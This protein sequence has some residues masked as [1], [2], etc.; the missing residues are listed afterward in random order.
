MNFKII[1]TSEDAI[2]E[3]FAL[4]DKVG[5]NVGSDV[6]LGRDEGWSDGGASGIPEGRLEGLSDKNGEGFWEGEP[7]GMLDGMN[8]GFGLGLIGYKIQFV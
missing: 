2:H 5:A 8:E 4:G 1:L 3:G 6:M 7:R